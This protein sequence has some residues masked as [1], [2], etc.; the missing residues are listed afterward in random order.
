LNTL[1]FFFHIAEGFAFQ[2]KGYGKSFTVYTETL[3]EKQEWMKILYSTIQNHKQNWA[4]QKHR[5]GVVSSAMTFNGPAAVWIPDDHA[6]YCMICKK[7][8]TVIKRRHH[9]RRC[10]MIVC[11]DCS[12]NKAIVLEVDK[13]KEVKVCDPCNKEL[14][15]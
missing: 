4:D 8:F 5:A 13:E 11:G 2:I 9:C 12:K 15:A 14:Q 3:E 7:E 10:G 6:R 1:L